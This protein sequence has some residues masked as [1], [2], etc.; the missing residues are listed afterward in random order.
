MNDED[1]VTK[2]FLRDPSDAPTFVREPVLDEAVR[3]NRPEDGEDLFGGEQV[4]HLGEHLLRTFRCVVFEKK[5][6][7]LR[8]DG[9]DVGDNWG[10]VVRRPPPDEN[11]SPE[12]ERDALNRPSGGLD[13]DEQFGDLFDALWEIVLFADEKLLRRMERHWPSPHDVDPVDGR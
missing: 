4:E 5:D 7:G 6:P 10:P 3:P 12:L 13:S 8:Q 2:E 9:V 1:R 11:R